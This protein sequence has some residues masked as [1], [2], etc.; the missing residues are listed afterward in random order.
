M[1]TKSFLSMGILNMTYFLYV[2]FQI[3]RE[4]E[5][6]QNWPLNPCQPALTISIYFFHIST[7]FTY[8]TEII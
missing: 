4:V 5:E 7:L 3:G 8:Q 6:P 1:L 2:T